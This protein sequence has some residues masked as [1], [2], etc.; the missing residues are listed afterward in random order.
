MI[1]KNTGNKII[2]IGSNMLMPDSQIR[3]GSGMGDNPAIAALAE[4]GYIKLIDEVDDGKRVSG[5]KASEKAEP[6]KKPAPAPEIEPE[7]ETETEAEPEPEAEEEPAPEAES[8]STAEQSTDTQDGEKETGEA[9]DAAEA[10][11]PKRVKRNFKRTTTAAPAAN[12]E[13]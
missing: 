9:A 3:V 6:A 5:K 13:T 2:N 10:E 1:I 4:K 8:S 12:P 7:P 11:A